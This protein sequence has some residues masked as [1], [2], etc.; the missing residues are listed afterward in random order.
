MTR[1]MFDPTGDET[2]RGRSQ[3][4]GPAPIQH[5]KM[6][7]GAIDG[8]TEIEDDDGDIDIDL[9]QPPHGADRAEDRSDIT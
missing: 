7:P 3:Y 5:S 2:E 4:L 9:D 1:S 6:P 8:K